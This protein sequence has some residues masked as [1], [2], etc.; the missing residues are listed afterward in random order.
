MNRRPSA[1]VNSAGTVV[2]SGMYGSRA[3]SC[4]TGRSASTNGRSLNGPA[5]SAGTTSPS[6]IWPVS[7]LAHRAGRDGGASGRRPGG[8]RHQ[9]GGDAQQDDRDGFDH[10]HGPGQPGAEGEVE[11]EQ[12]HAADQDEPDDGA[13]HQGRRA[14][15]D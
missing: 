2:M 5:A 9:Q 10:Q 7:P 15:H 14:Q 12:A 6:L 8:A 4:T 1:S 11:P 13:G 3:A